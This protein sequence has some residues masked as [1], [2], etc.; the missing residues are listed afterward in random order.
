MWMCVWM[1]VCLCVDVRVC[2]C[3]HGHLL[4]L[5]VKPLMFLCSRLKSIMLAGLSACLTAPHKNVSFKCMYLWHFYKRHWSNLFLLY[6]SWTEHNAWPETAV[7][8]NFIVCLVSS[9]AT[10]GVFLNVLLWLLWHVWKKNMSE[11]VLMLIII[12]SPII[13]EC[14]SA[15][16]GQGL[17]GDL[18]NDLWR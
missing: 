4:S 5:A 11:S 16:V 14:L 18:Q 15:G 2:V 12:S 10:A 7:R 13:S 9:S 1:C 17:R 6:F 8:C 3:G